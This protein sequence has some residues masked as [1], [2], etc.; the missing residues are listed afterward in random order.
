MG[1]K[2]LQWTLLSLSL[3]SVIT[4]W[5]LSFSSYSVIKN[6]NWMYF[7]EYE[8]VYRRELVFTF[9]EHLTCS[10]QN[11][12]L[13]ILV[14]SRPSEVG[15]R[16]AVRATWGEKRSW[17]GHEV[18]TFFLV[19][20]QAQREDN[21][22]TLS[23]EDE[24]I[25][26]GDIIGQDF[27]D[28]YENLTLKTILAFRWVTE[29]CP[30]AKYIMKTDSDVFINT[31]NLVKFLLNTNSSENFF[32][33]Y[34]LIN[35]FSYRGFYQKTYISYE[36]YPFKV[37]PPYCSGM[38]YVLSADL[39]PRIYEMMGHVKPI[40]FEDAY[41]GICL[42]ILRVNIHIPEDT[43]L[44]FLYKISFNICKFRHLIAAHDFSANEMMRFWQE[45]QRATTVT[46]P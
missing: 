23:L 33:G 10:T 3:L 32:T 27:V 12:F 30:N 37:F 45:L 25:L 5:Y 44:F 13:V 36:E 28:T 15:A 8:P 7:Y 38:G 34:P 16:Q 39:A 40:K 1:V 26:Y 14:T 31:G 43:N 24:S 2:F 6:V 11:P 4:M 42:N 35:N 9:R 29:F 19:G 46:C 20:Q 18:L 41:V 17:W 22:L 21:M